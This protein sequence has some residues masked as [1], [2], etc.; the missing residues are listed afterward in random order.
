[1]ADIKLDFNKKED[2][3]K[4]RH[5]TSHVLA[6]AVKTLFPKATLAIGPAIDE[7]FYY[8]FDVE[9]PFT[10]EMLEQIEAR[11]E[12]IIGAD[13]PFEREEM[14][15]ENAIEYFKS[16]GEP[17]KV[18]LLQEIEDQ[19][20]TIYR[21]GDFVDLCRGPHLKST[22][23]I[24]SF[25]LL[26]VAGSYWR[27]SEKNKMLQRIYGTCFPSRKE[28]RAHLKRLE[29]AKKRD[30]R[31]LG[32]ELDLFST[33]EIA[34]SGLIYWHPKGA[35]I[36][37]LIEN[38]WR[39]EHHRRGYDI[40]YTPHIFRE[41][42][43][44]TSG[45]LDFYRENMYSPMDIDGMDYYIKPMNCP[46]HILIYKTHTR[47]Y[48][49]LPIRL[50]EL[51]TVYRYERSGTLHGMARV[52]GF[53]QD[54]AHIFCTPDQLAGEIL[55]VVEFA[56]FMMKLFGFEYKTYLATRP[57][58]SIGTDALWEM[59]TN[60]LRSAL[61]KFGKEFDIDEGGGVF[62]GPK[63]DIKLI[64]AI[65][66][67][68][69]G[70]TIQL[71]FNF[72]EKFNLSYIGPDGSQ[73]Q[74]VMIHRVVLGSM[75]RFMGVLIEH[76]EGAFPVW[77]APEQVKILTVT[78][79]HIEYGKKV[80]DELLKQDL[81][82]VLDDRNEKLGF[83][84]RDSQTHKIPYS[85]VIGQKEIDSGSVAVRKYREGMLG[86]MTVDEFVRKIKTEEQSKQLL[87]GGQ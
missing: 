62:Y 73:H 52:R 79:D 76:F 13:R 45:H 4:Y 18:E 65:G 69:Q 56:D 39:D 53:T 78:D 84:I 82:V 60:G 5:S 77:L 29:E 11:M 81:R 59:A 86:T 47:S 40:V 6:H 49:E 42:L 36:R 64:D 74:P 57:E 80:R 54:D 67:E 22:G 44:R 9:Q 51:G 21:E 85:L 3:D 27:G 31:K 35:R 26:S 32:K 15:R 58:K 38:F 66:R 14:G 43:L 1:M 7:G 30:H 8:D 20:V 12:E 41:D 46:G 55:G 87:T 71:D 16:L 83:K 17:Y 10:P 63:I 61:D 50:A 75:E 24:K 70:P 19:L 48:K 34:G 33:H 23:E 37:E 28:L 68:W 72:A 2:R 25:K